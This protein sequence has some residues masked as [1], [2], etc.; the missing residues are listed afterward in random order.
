MFRDRLSVDTAVQVRLL[1]YA[2]QF[3]W[4]LF[5]VLKTM[6]DKCQSECGS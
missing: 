5:L 2:L 4:I 6:E 3:S 1:S